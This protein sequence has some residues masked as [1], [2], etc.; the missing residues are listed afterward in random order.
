MELLS[1]YG[2]KMKKEE[3]ECFWNVCIRVFCPNDRKAYPN[4]KKTAQKNK[5]EVSR[6]SAFSYYILEEQKLCKMHYYKRHNF[7]KYTIDTSS[8]K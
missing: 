6:R 1:K 3:K 2:K 5:T 8:K 4:V 7:T